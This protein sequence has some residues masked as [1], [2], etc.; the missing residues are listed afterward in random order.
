MQQLK[1]STQRQSR[2]LIQRHSNI[3]NNTI[4]ITDKDNTQQSLTTNSQHKR[5]LSLQTF[6]SWFWIIFPNI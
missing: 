1:T 3:S 5:Q 6:Q 2:H 4:K